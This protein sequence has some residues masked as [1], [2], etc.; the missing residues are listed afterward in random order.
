MPLSDLTDERRAQL[1][2]IG[3][4]YFD[5]AKALDVADSFERAKAEQLLESI[6]HSRRQIGKALNPI[7]EDA[8]REL[9]GAVSLRDTLCEPL[10]RAERIL[11]SR[12]GDYD[13]RIA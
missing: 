9:R 10:D 12:A 2:E 3:S 7:I 6:A 5:L 1:R 4:D 11:R 8:R 13:A